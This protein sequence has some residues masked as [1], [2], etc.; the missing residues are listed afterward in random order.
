MPNKKHIKIL[1]RGAKAWNKWGKKHPNVR[2]DLG[3]A[4]LIGA[5]LRKFNFSGLD[6]TEKKLLRSMNKK[7]KAVG[8]PKTY[9]PTSPTNLYHA[10]LTGA[11]LS[12]AK[13]S[14]ADLTWA[15]L[16]KANLKGADL[17]GA[18]LLFT[19]FYE[20]DLTDTEFG[21]AQVGWT[22]FA[23]TNLAVA[24][25]LENTSHLGPSSIGIDTIVKSSGNIPETFLKAAGVPDSVLNTLNFFQEPTAQFHSCFIS[26]SNKDE[27]LAER[28]YDDL[29]TKGV[30]CWFAPANLK[31]GDKL[32]PV[33]D[34]AIRLHDKLMVLLSKKSIKS[35]WVEKEVETAF[36]RE[37]QQN[38]MVLLPIRLDDAVM[39][40]KEAWA[41]DIRRTRHI[42]DFRNWT[43]RD[44]YKKAFN[45]LLRD[46]K[47]KGKNVSGAS[48]T[49]K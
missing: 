38:R 33:L 3:E 10:D 36:E 1:K 21:D 43:D 23:S 7:L 20:T 41:A 42:G 25:G 14:Y 12:D 22:K 27:D 35:P 30:R 11:D 4:S 34:D 28:L 31:T 9:M 29:Q 26:Y 2:P 47:A 32:R 16:S 37:R 19:E 15:H 49:H 8:R 6:K 18:R 13:L 44:S 17:S 40:A 48:V 39:E 5:D 24:T 46:L 45:R